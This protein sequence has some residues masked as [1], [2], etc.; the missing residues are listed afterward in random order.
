MKPQKLKR[1]V[2][3]EELVALTGHYVKALILN[4]MIFWSERV[5][6]FDLFL[7]ETKKREENIEVELRHGWI[8]KN[9]KDLSGE[10]MIDASHQTI[11]R[12]MQ[13]LIEDGFIEERH[14]PKQAWDRTMQYRV[15][16]VAVIQGLNALGYGLEG[17]TLLDTSI[18]QNGQSSVQNGQS[19]VG[20]GRAIPEITTKI[21]EQRESK[22]ADPVPTEV[23][24]SMA[25]PLSL[26]K[27]IVTA[28]PQMQM[29]NQTSTVTVPA[30]PLTPSHRYDVRKFVEGFVPAGTG[31]TACE[32]YYERFSIHDVAA[33][34]S[35][36]LQDDLWS[37]CKDMAK[38]RRVIVAYSQQGSFRPKNIKLIIQWYRGGIPDYARVPD[39]ESEVEGTPRMP[40]GTVRGS[41]AGLL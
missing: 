31:E 38:L 1:V 39:E 28:R 32:V 6:D 18:V 22:A 17:Y 35:A 40:E 4:Q 25:S 20:N 9:A 33:R 13:A 36:P 23:A 10:L 11:R 7:A 12:Y 16:L 24:P 15:D 8:Y 34:L 26:S 14:N 29:G 37:A 27:K 21:K 41:L 30:K 2:I 19:S 3:K 5:S